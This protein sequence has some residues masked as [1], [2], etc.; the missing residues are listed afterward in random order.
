MAENMF[1]SAGR[2]YDARISRETSGSSIF[3]TQKIDLYA[4]IYGNYLCP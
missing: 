4:G 2:K 1:P 3:T